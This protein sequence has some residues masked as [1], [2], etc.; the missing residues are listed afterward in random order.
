MPLVRNVL[1][2]GIVKGLGEIVQASKVEAGIRLAVRAPFFLQQKLT[3]NLGDSICISGVCLTVVEVGGDVIQFDVSSETLRRTNFSELKAGDKVNLEPALRLGDALDGHL[4]QGHVDGVGTVGTRSVEG[5]T[6]RFTISAPA[7]LLPLIAEK[8]SIAV[9]GVSL[10]VGETES[11]KFAIYIIPFTLQ[12]TT[13][14][15]YVSGQRVN[16]EVDVI[17][18]YVARQLEFKGES[19]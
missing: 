12:E 15:N 3:V 19:R 17:A 2:S 7:K 6:V 11:D 4:V 5:E 14:A 10:T 8:G 1:F 13:L 18:R 16:L 9:D